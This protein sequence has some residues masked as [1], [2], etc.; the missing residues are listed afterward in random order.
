MVA[1]RNGR[2]AVEL[3]T[4]AGRDPGWTTHR[5]AG[6]QRLVAG[7]T[8][9]LRPGDELAVRPINHLDQLTDLHTHGLRVSPQANWGNPF[10]RVEPVPRSPTLYRI[11]ADLNRPGEWR[12]SD[13]AR[14]LDQ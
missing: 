8:L 10:V 12:G 4:A 13:L 5:S 9:R 3:T 2:L 7:P 14:R 6:L 11:P 1:S